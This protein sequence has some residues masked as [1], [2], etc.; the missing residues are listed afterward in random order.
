MRLFFTRRNE[1]DFQKIIISSLV[2][3]LIFIAIAVIPASPKKREIKNYY[4]NLVSPAAIRQPDRRRVSGAD[5][6]ATARIKKIPPKKKIIA[7]PKAKMSLKSPTVDSAIE[8]IKSKKEK[9]KEKVEELASIKARIRKDAAKAAAVEEAAGTDRAAE[10]SNLY[11]GIGSYD[12]R[13]LYETKVRDHITEHWNTP[14]FDMEGLAA[15]YDIRVDK[16]WKIFSFKRIESSGNSLFDRSVENAMR[17]AQESTRIFP[18]PEPP[19]DMQ[20]E[21]LKEGFEVKFDPDE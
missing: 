16:D 7:K 19:L 21:I 12:A 1:P 13:L 8:K 2:F 3:H 17:D 6:K 11:A 15:V 10:S 18:L 4:V 20:K 14:H 9:E 5:K